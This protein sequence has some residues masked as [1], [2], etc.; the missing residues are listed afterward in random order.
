MY[1]EYYLAESDNKEEAAKVYFEKS[2][3]INYFMYF[4]DPTNGLRSYIN[5]YQNG[6]YLD[7][8]IDL[9]PITEWHFNSTYNC[10]MANINGELVFLGTSDT[11]TYDNVCVKRI[12]DGPTYFKVELIKAETGTATNQLS[13]QLAS[14]GNGYIVTGAIS[15]SGANLEI[16]A[17]YNGKPVRCIAA[18]AFRNNTTITSVKIPRSILAI[19]VGAFEGVT[20][21]QTFCYEG[22]DEEWAEIYY[23][24]REQEINE[25]V[26]FDCLASTHLV[27]PDTKD[28]YF[29]YDS[30]GLSFY[31]SGI[32]EL[33]DIDYNT[34]AIP[35]TYKGLPVIGI[36]DYAFSDDDQI[37]TVFI[38]DSIKNIGVGAFDNVWRLTRVLYGGNSTEWDMIAIGE[39]NEA[40]N[41]D[42]NHF[43]V[44]VD[45][46][47][48]LIGDIEDTNWSVDFMMTQKGTN[49]WL[50]D[51]LT[52]DAGS[53]LKVRLNGEWVIDFGM[54]L[55][56]ENYVVKESGVYQIKFVYD[57]V[58]MTGEI[59]L[60]P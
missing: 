50:S 34:I 38:P 15:L 30:D 28:F 20:N 55:G 4:I 56:G 49:V 36:C 1:N 3:V 45:G 26:Y 22:F 32:R 9:D 40:L 43:N 18:G 19:G 44:T 53:E 29:V 25:N 58:R 60:I 12:S 2:P 16:P 11:G 35:S 21:L 10:L 42:Q 39:G 59:T 47:W 27:K 41:T 37:T 23:P 31:V 24:T 6:E 7:L 51:Y 54:T 5:V 17:T 33:A 14:D 8:G 57:P 13:Y 52:W 46:E 48:T